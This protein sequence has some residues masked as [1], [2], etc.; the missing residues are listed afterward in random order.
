MADNPFI[1]HLELLF[2]YSYRIK[3]QRVIQLSALAN[4]DIEIVKSANC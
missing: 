4:L 3:S 2:T 1:N